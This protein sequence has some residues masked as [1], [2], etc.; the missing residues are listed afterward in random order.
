MAPWGLGEGTLVVW[1][2]GVCQDLG[3]PPH[4]HVYRP[5]NDRAT[6]RV[7]APPWPRHPLRAYP[8]LPRVEATRP[9]CA[10]LAQA[11]WATSLSRAATVAA[12]GPAVHDWALQADEGRRYVASALAAE[13]GT[14]VSGTVG[15]PLLLSRRGHLSPDEADAFLAGMVES[16]YRSPVRSIAET[17][18]LPGGDGAS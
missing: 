16:G 8:S 6:H 4:H 5:A 9:R 2:V 1:A 17:A 10:K 7:V 18:R 13:I 14:A 15:V 12:G 11:G 3:S